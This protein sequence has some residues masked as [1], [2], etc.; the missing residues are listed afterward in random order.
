MTHPAPGIYAWSPTPGR[1]GVYFHRMQEPLRVAGKQGVRTATGIGMDD[2]VAE[3]YDTILAHMLN[4]PRESE[5]WEKLARNGQHRLVF[6]IDDVMWAPDWTDFREAYTDDV[7]A[8]VWRNLSMAHVVTT[9]SPVIAEH[10]A[11]YNRNVWVVPNTVPAAL[12]HRR[13]RRRPA[14]TL[15]YQGS[16]HHMVNM[17]QGIETVL[18]RLLVDNPGWLMKRWGTGGQTVPLANHGRLIHVDW[19]ESPW[20]YYRTVSMDIGIGPL[21]RTPFTAGKSAL[22][23]IEYAALGIPAV[24]TDWHPYRGWV[25]PGVTGFLVDEDEDW[26]TPI[27]ALMRDPELREKMGRTARERAAAWTTEAAIGAWGE[28]W[29][30]V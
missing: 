9:P 7:L 10:V 25:E 19:I 6:D 13:M 16:A 18:G 11:K 12:L 22:R 15:G 8:R 20:D 14:P 17:D 5:A 3:G 28:A 27:S 21:K 29:N 24:L 23:A 2:R 26:Y 30:S 4:G 1:G